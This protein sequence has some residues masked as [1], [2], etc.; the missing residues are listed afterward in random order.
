MII[1]SVKMDELLGFKKGYTMLMIKNGFK[2]ARGY[3]L[4]NKVWV[5]ESENA[6]MF[7]LQYGDSKYQKVVTYLKEREN[8]V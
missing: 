4:D 7:A 3:K 8:I 2:K 1:T 5:M 6:L